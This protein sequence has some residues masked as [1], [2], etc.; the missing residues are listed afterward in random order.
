MFKT[1]PLTVN[2]PVYSWQRHGGSIKIFGAGR[3]LAAYVIISCKCCEKTAAP[4][5][6]RSVFL[7][8]RELDSSF[9]CH[10][11]GAIILAIMWASAFYSLLYL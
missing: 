11:S 9:P 10:V 1:V 4:I 2:C 6:C 7:A 3:K 5:V 8:G